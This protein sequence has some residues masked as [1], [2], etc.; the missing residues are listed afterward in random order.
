MNLRPLLRTPVV[1]ETLQMSSMSKEPGR[2]F[3]VVETDSASVCEVVFCDNV[4]QRTMLHVALIAEMP[5]SELVY[6]WQ[7]L[8]EAIALQNPTLEKVA[9]AFFLREFNSRASVYSDSAI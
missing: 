5:P 7:M 1:G 8:R 6:A 4:Q 2:R 3:V 9:R